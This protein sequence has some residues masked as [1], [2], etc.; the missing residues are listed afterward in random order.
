MAGTTMYA[1]KAAL[2]TKL[3]ADISGVL[4]D[5]GYAS[6]AQYLADEKNS[7]QGLAQLLNERLNW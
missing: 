5:A 4:Q 1:T 6:S 2:L 7:V 3:Q